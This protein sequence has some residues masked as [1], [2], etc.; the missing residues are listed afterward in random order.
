MYFPLSVRKRL[1][2]ATFLPILDGDYGDILYMHANQ[3][4][5]KMLDS[6]YHAALR[7]VTNSDFRTYHCSFMNVL[8]GFFA[9]S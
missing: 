2:Q 9:Q 5:L 8:V 1:I 6:I 3:S 7:F 4:A